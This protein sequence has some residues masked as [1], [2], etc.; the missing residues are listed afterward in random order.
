MD[1][2]TGKLLVATDGLFDPNFAKSVV[3]IVQHGDEGALGVIV[4][5]PLAV[6]VRAIWQ[7]VG[8][9]DCLIEGVVHQG[10]PCEGPLMVLHGDADAS[11]L[12]VNADIHFTTNKDSIQKL[13]EAGMSPTKF[14]VGYAGWG[15]GQVE[16]EVA[17]GSWLVVPA[18]ADHVFEPDGDLWQSLHKAANR[19]ARASWLPAERIP[20]DPSVN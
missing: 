16:D 3:L 8:E 7:Q 6:T 15:K 2:L 10:G 4:N 17:S 9:S 18:A 1:P 12:E 20:D 13:V 5:R 14:F 19:T 11:D